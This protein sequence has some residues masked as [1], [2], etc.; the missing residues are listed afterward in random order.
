MKATS[1]FGGV[2]VFNIIISVVKS[3]FVAV[4]LGPAGMGISGLLT[5]TTT[6][7]GT[8]T[9]FGLNTSAVKNIAEANATG[10]IKRIS[11][12]ASV[13]R[14][15]VWITGILGTLVTLVLSPLLSDLTF[16]N[17]D[18]TVAFMWISI[19]LL[20]TQ[21]SNGQMVVL[22]GM[23]K[24]Q[25]LAKA[26]LA[27]TTAS[28]FISVPIYYIWGIDGIVP[29]LIFSSVGTLIF[30]W[31]FAS[32]LKIESVKVNKSLL[33]TEGGD[34]IRLGFIL[35]VNS[36]IA[37]GASYIVRIFVSR[38]G[39][40]EQVGLYNAGFT[41]I[42]T[43]VGM[44]FTAMSTDYFPRLSGIARDN[45]MAR[46]IIN[47][48]AEIA[49]LILAP[50]LT[51]FLIFIN[52]V[53]LLFYSSRFVAVD[54]MIHWAALGIFFKAPSWAIAFLFVAKGHTRLFFYNELTAN[55]YM[56]AFNV[57]GYKLGGLE[58]LGISFFVGYMIY[59]SQVYLIARKKYGYFFDK[60]FQKIF[61]I[62]FILGLI[63]FAGAKFLDEIVLYISGAFIIGL[64]SLYSF[65]ELDKR[66]GL[67]ALI[68]E[69]LNKNNGN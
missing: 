23:R 7:I 16:G 27:G 13:L 17:R 30:S 53:V 9:N 8:V 66:I 69:R 51:V 68:T 59:L 40:I 36:L 15:L 35:S 37:V 61:L 64:S 62:Q 19:T 11:D 2:Q 5:S 22:Q 25:F 33:Y 50:I 55:L 52:Y 67:K 57:L 44:V 1:I 6:F 56:L 46:N 39:G 24:L 41:I 14:K 49:L 18:Y 32:K 54:S 10:D 26:N 29:A 65:K 48:Q 47:Q 38:L 31:L 20:L 3:K 60:S 58:G 43:Y 4:L 34:M 12:V 28:L 45:D 21:I 42:N 63:C